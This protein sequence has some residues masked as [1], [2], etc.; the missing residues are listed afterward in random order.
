M[1]FHLNSVGKIAWVS[2]FKEKEEQIGAQFTSASQISYMPLKTSHWCSEMTGTKYITEDKS[3]E[4]NQ[5][6]LLI[7][8]IL[9]SA[10]ILL[11]ILFFFF[12]RKWQGESNV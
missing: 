8:V 3:V 7:H 1:F 10:E 12:I 4:D 9:P 5:I 6:F 11:V 2:F